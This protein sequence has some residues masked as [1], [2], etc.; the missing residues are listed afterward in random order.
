MVKAKR[1][2]NVARRLRHDSTDAERKLW[3]HVRDRRLDGLKFRRQVPITGYVDDFLCVDA[4]LIVELDGGQHAVQT[5]ADAKRTQVL[6][7]AGYFVLRF[8]N[9]DVLENIDGVLEEILATLR[10]EGPSPQPSPQRGEG[11]R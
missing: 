8:W 4:R 11:A 1:P 3:S 5:A 2:T 7:A 6:E 10:P 9:N